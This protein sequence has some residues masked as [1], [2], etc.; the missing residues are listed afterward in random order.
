MRDDQA[1]FPTKE[2]DHPSSR[3]IEDQVKPDSVPNTGPSY[4][5][6]RPVLHTEQSQGEQEAGHDD[7]NHVTPSECHVGC[8]NADSPD[9]HQY[10]THP[11]GE[12]AGEGGHAVRGEDYSVVLVRARLEEVS[13]GNAGCYGSHSAQQ[14]T[15]Y[16]GEVDEGDHVTTSRNVVG[17]EEE[18]GGDTE[19]S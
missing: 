2:E 12:P 1:E 8:D 13:Q 10:Q 7:W 14:V 15:W 11:G 5:S 4:I 18:V 17:E 9:Q 19:E 3:H 16:E 6:L